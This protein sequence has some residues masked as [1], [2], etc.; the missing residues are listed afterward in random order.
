[1]DYGSPPEAVQDGGCRRRRLLAQRRAC[2]PGLPRGLVRVP[3]TRTSP[4]AAPAPR[5]IELPVGRPTSTKAA[6]HDTGEG[7]VSSEPRR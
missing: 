6:P 1:M 3:A 2:C 7:V 5:A 4:S